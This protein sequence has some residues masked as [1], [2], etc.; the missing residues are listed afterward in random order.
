MMRYYWHHRNEWPGSLNQMYKV[1]GMSKQAFHKHLN[2]YN[3]RKEEQAHLLPI[4]YQIRAD[5]PTMCCRYMYH[6]IQPKYLGR[7]RFEDLCRNHGLMNKVSKSRRRTTDSSGVIRFDNLLE[8]TILTRIN[9][10]WSSD[11]TYFQLGQSFFYLTFI[12]DC[13]SR[14]I[15][16]HQTSHRLLTT[17]T[18]LPALDLALKTRRHTIPPELIFHS[19]GGGQYYEAQFLNLT[20]QYKMKNSMCKYAYQND[21]AER[22]NGIIKNNYLRH[23][24]I[25]NETQL[26][27]SV[28]RAVYLYNY[29]KPHSSLEMMTPIQYEDMLSNLSQNTTQDNGHSVSSAEPPSMLITP[30]KPDRYLVNNSIN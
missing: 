6:M 16:G 18:T 10:A 7:D 2:R 26:A 15:I 9:Q 8:H 12:L 21:K 29:Q 23:W 25:K 27:R 5:H 1:A 20:A 14:R 17:S 28:D 3:C 22:I 11:I 19:D 24:N 30:K 4:I 13:Y